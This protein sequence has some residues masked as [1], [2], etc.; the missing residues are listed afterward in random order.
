MVRLFAR[1]LRWLHDAGGVTG[2]Q[3]AAAVGTVF[4]TAVGGVHARAQLHHRS[5]LQDVDF[6]G[7]ASALDETVL[8]GISSPHAGGAGY[9]IRHGVFHGGIMLDVS[10]DNKKTAP[11][12]GLRLLKKYLRS[13]VRLRIPSQGR[14]TI[15]CR[16]LYLAAA[17]QVVSVAALPLQT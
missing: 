14:R 9:I 2:L 17:F 4:A 13:C 12:D 16:F 5:V 7:I 15:P 1:R 6:R 10:L 3:I 8:I 11:R